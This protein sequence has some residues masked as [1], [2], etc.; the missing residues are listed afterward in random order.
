MDG[1]IKWQI[2]II[3]RINFQVNYSFNSTFWILL[4]LA[5]KK[6]LMWPFWSLNV[7][8][9]RIKVRNSSEIIHLYPYWRWVMSYM[10]SLTIHIME[11]EWNMERKG[12]KMFVWHRKKSHQASSTSITDYHKCFTFTFTVVE[13]L[14]QSRLSL[15]LSSQHWLKISR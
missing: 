15:F 1:W 8:D 14:N 12:H 2:T 3:I 6:Y 5:C 7:A 11:H 4:K 13:I 10:P 9:K